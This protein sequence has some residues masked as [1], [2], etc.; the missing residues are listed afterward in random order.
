MQIPSKDGGFT[1]VFYCFK[2]HYGDKIMGIWWESI[3]RWAPTLATASCQVLEDVVFLPSWF[4]L[5]TCLEQAEMLA[6][7]VHITNPLLKGWSWY[8]SLTQKTSHHTHDG[9]RL[10]ENY[11]EIV[12]K[13][14]PKCFF[15]LINLHNRIDWVT[16][17]NKHI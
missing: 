10:A 12:S 7:K 16:D 13:S 8:L 1:I 11:P 14:H 4:T 15:C 5:G 17:M 2:P 3:P 9:S 6:E